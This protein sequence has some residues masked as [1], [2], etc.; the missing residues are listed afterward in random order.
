[1]KR[2]LIYICLSYCSLLLLSCGKNFLDI[3]QIDKLTGNNYWTSK[4]DVEQYL[5]GIYGSFRAATM[6]NIFF[7]ASGDLRCAPI[8]RTSAT[9]GEGRDYLSF[10]RTNNL[11]AIFARLDDFSYFGFDQITKWNTFYKMVQNANILYYELENREMPFLSEA[12]V[13]RYKAEAVFLRSLAYFFMVR[14]YGD[15]PFYTTV[16][17]D[18][19]PRTNMLTVLENIST[20]LDVHYQDLPWTFDDPSIVAVRAMRGSA[21]VLNMHIN[22]W[23]AGFTTADKSANYRKVAELGREIMEENNGAYELLPLSRTREIFKGRTREGLFEIVQ[24]YNFGETFHLSASFS[25]YVL[26]APNKVT[27]N[28]YIYYESR[29]FEKLYPAAQQDLRKVYWFDEYIYNTTG[30]FQ[31]LKFLNVFMEEGEDANPDDNQM[32]FRY[33]DAI[34]LRAEALAELNSD[35]EARE[36]V[37][38]VRRR[39][40][41]PNITDEGDDLKDAIWW[42]RARELFGEG[43]FYYD[44][45]RTGKVINSEYT[46]APMSVAAYRNGGWTWPIDAAALA[47]N[48]FMQLNNFWTN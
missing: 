34:L 15:V 19:L 40:Q 30:L 25:D 11:N 6:S 18:P 23:I 8:I 7:P 20:D 29:F 12:D 42:E 22:M 26:R 39:A 47:N 32:V 21:I 9:A 13:S 35:V 36:V 16:N 46:T 17:T 43:N 33:V 44:L 45:V 37:N 10:L 4:N 2:K 27:P 28:S 48:P 41:A 38:V 24:N 1:M 3:T 14:I 31:C 5:G